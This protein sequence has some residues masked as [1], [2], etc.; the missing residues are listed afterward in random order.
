ML[1]NK[2]THW[3]DCCLAA[4]LEKA[5]DILDLAKAVKDRLDCRFWPEW[6]EGQT[7][8]IACEVTACPSFESAME[9]RSHA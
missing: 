7:L 5:E 3:E 6:K 4:L 2:C 8:S 9:V 1:C